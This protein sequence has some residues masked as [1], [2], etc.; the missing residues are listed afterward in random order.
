MMARLRWLENQQ[1]GSTAKPMHS[2]SGFS[3]GD[4]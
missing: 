4:K 1:G 3:R 2:L